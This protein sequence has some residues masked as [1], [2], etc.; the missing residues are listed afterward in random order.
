[1]ANEVI[2]H[3]HNRVGYDFA[4]RQAGAK[5]VEIGVEG[6]ATAAELEEGITD[7]TAALLYFYNVNRMGGLVPLEQGIEIAHQHNVPVIV[8]AAAQVPPV[9]N[10]WRFTQMGADLVLFS[11]GKG[12][13]GPQ[14]SGL[15]LGRKH[16]IEACAF[17]ACPN[18]FIGRPM[19]VGKEEMIG[20]MTAVRWYL[21]QD[22]E[23]LMQRYEDQVQYAVDVLEA[24][25]HVTARR[26]FPSEAGQ[27]MPRA[28]ITLDEGAL[29]LTGRD[30]LTRLRDGSPSVALQP[31]GKNGVYVNP[32]TLEPGQAEIVVTR[33]A[34]ILAKG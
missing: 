32:Q 10:L 29:G 31:A 23:A 21:D 18:A 13:R 12:L 16:L 11:G 14:S 33:I 15:I 20:L 34:E 19:K 4:M 5:L 24:L 8:D 28:E 1:M 17:H 2:V 27:P 6:A 3:K 22:H 30:L 25:P 26:S 7:K 9:E